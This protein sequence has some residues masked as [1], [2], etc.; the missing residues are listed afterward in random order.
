MDKAVDFGLEFTPVGKGL[1]KGDVVVVV[2]C[3]VGKEAP[4]FIGLPDMLVE[5]AKAGGVCPQESDE[6]VG[7]QLVGLARRAVWL[8]IEVSDVDRVMLSSQGS[9]S[10]GNTGVDELDEGGDVLVARV[11]DGDG[12]GREVAMVLF[13]PL[14]GF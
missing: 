8:R 2:A 14:R 7:E 4:V 5:G 10:T 1:F 13:K 11:V 6:P 9:R 3:Q 12:E